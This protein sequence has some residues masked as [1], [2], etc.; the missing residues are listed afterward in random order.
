[1]I[2]IKDFLIGCFCILIVAVVCALM[3]TELEVN[4]DTKLMQDCCCDGMFCSDTIYNGTHCIIGPGPFQ[5]IERAK[6]PMPHDN[7]ED[8]VA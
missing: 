8:L 1:M 7:V 6:C 2:S 5:T 3:A 4:I